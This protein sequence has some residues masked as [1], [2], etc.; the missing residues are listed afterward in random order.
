L[1]RPDLAKTAGI[2]PL[3]RPDLEDSGLNPA[4]LAGS[5]QL[6][7]RNPATATGRCR[8][9]A[10]ITKLLFLHFVIFS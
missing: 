10:T 6:S 5:G 2:R 9:P 8:I 7:G 4:I 3:I 1:I